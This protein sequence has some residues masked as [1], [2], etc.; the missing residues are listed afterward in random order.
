MQ[1]ADQR[2]CHHRVQSQG[3][4][5]VEDGRGTADPRQETGSSTPEK[6]TRVILLVVL[7]IGLCSVLYLLGA[8]QA[9]R[10]GRGDCI[11]AALNEQTKNVV[12]SGLHV[13]THLV[14]GATPSW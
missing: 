12:L 5:D 7:V 1:L 2:R 10:F 8:W 14:L 4:G 6:K 11:A 9:K 13:E 3:L